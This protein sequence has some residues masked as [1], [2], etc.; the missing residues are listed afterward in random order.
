[1]SILDYQ[2]RFSAAQAITLLGDT[3]SENVIDLSIARDIGGA[4]TD[5]LML[6]CQV[7]TAFTSN[8]SA[9]LK[10]TFQASNTEGS[11]YVDIVSSAA[12]PV[13]SLTAGYKFLQNEVP[14]FISSTLYRYIRLNYTVGTAAMTAGNVTAGLTPALQHAPV[15]SAG[16]VA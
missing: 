6:L 4:V 13:A 1:M 14:S 3:A 10:V 12:V 7:V 2:N 8:G 5:H 15:Y 11:G 9:T 16:Y